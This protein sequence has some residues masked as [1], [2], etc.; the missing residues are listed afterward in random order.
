MAVKIVG[1][2]RLHRDCAHAPLAQLNLRTIHGWTTPPGE[3]SIAVFSGMGS[4]HAKGDVGLSSVDKVTQWQGIPA[5]VAGR[6]ENVRATAEKFR[7]KWQNYLNEIDPED[8]AQRL[9]DFKPEYDWS[10]LSDHSDAVHQKK[11]GE[12]RVSPELRELAIDGHKLFEAFFRANSELR[13]WVDLLHPGH[14]INISWLPTAGPGWVA[15][16]PWGLMY[17]LN[18]PDPGD[19]VDPMGS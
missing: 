6:I 13:Q 15:S 4:V 9:Q 10:F 11:W 1:P 8:L 7:A 3:L 16:V 12:V 17:Q 14:R 5:M 19:P 2:A 18:P